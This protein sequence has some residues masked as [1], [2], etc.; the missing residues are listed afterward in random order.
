MS[1]F[2][3]FVL[4]YIITSI[5]HF[6]TFLFT[7]KPMFQ[8]RNFESFLELILHSVLWIVAI[9]EYID[10]LQMHKQWYHNLIIKYED[11]KEEKYKITKQFTSLHAKHLILKDIYVE[12]VQKTASVLPNGHKLIT[13]IQECLP[14]KEDHYFPEMT[15]NDMVDYI[16]VQTNKEYYLSMYICKKYS[17]CKKQCPF[18]NPR[19]YNTIKA[20]PGDAC[21]NF[22]AVQLF[23][24]RKGQIKYLI[25]KMKNK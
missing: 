20:C 3:F 16:P 25:S 8:D 18:K 24:L 15:E 23:D 1:V 11:E 12:Y 17:I 13:S 5:C 9:Y 6:V 22:I 14:S 19:S 7:N 21:S 2:L 4:F 10:T